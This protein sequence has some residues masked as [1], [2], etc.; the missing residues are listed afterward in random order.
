MFSV[1]F[2]I[3]SPIEIVKVDCV[4]SCNH[5]CIRKRKTKKKE[6]EKIQAYI[7]RYYNKTSSNYHANEQQSKAKKAE[8]L[9]SYIQGYSMHNITLKWD[10]EYTK[11]VILNLT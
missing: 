2:R 3:K 10:F 7:K 11:I 5:V 8:P 9:T 1:K 4:G 6:I